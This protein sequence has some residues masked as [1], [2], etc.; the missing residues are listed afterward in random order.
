MVFKS[1]MSV[2][3]GRFMERSGV[4]PP[5]S[6]LIGK[7]W[8]PMMHF[9]ACSIHCNVHSGVGRRLGSHRLIS[10]KSLIGSTFWAF[11][12]SSALWVLEVLCCLYWHSF[13]Q[14]DH[15]TLWSM[16]I[17]VNWLTLCQE[18]HRAVFLGLLLFHLYTSKLL[19][20]LKNKL[21]G[22]A[23]DSTLMTVVH[24]QAL[25]VT[26][27]ESMISDPGRVSEWCDH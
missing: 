19:S 10:V 1:L 16:V 6:L 24:S 17:E 25:R 4:P 8:V 15:S 20:I 2:R 9:C 27:A 26:V 23:D 22:Y 13:N 5:P 12:I 11:S 3:Q 18:C 14:T 21:I 7:V